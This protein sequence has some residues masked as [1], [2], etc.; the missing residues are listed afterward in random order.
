MAKKTT[1]VAVIAHAGKTFGGGLVELHQALAAAGVSAPDWYEVDKSK[2]APKAVR[3]AVEKGAKLVFVWGGD[4]MV[5]HCATGLAGTGVAMAILPAGTANLLAT[6]FEIP[7]NIEEAVAIGLS[8]K[9]K[10]L[11]AGLI[12]GEHFLVMAGTGFDA[13]IM[14]DVNAKAKELVGR[15]AYFTSTLKAMAMK[16]VH[17]EVVLD[18][19]VFFEGKAS[20]IL[21]GNI[22][23][24][25]AGAPVFPHANPSDGWLEVGVVTAKNAWQW[26]RV[27]GRVATGKVEKSPF[28]SF[29]RAKHADVYLRSA[30]PFELDGGTRDKAK[31]LVLDIAPRAITLCIP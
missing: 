18:G 16:R 6:E 11:D 21:F 2:K 29:A 30:R 31:H 26:M 1:H 27:F 13:T 9:T 10:K 22:G 3:K 17:A 23:T 12:N 15:V 8:G 4:G 28:I 25:T 24:I 20:M 7:K 19:E 14:D 5:Q